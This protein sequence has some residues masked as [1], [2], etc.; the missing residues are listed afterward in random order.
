MSNLNLII[1][2]GGNSS[3]REVSI[4]TGEAIFN[5]LKKTSY[6]ELLDY[7]GNINEYLPQL[8]KAD[9]VVLAL[10]GGEGENG[11]I[12]SFFET[13]G[14]KFTGSNS[15]SSKIAMD[16]NQTKIIAQNNLIS[17]PKWL[18]Y[19]PKI[20][21]K[22]Q[23]PEIIKLGFPLV[24]KPS[25]EGSTMGL[26]IIQNDAEITI[27]LEL[28]LKY[29]NKVMFEE[30]IPG[31]ELTVG[32]LGDSFLPIVEIIPSHELYDYECKYTKGMSNYFCPAGIDV[33]VGLKIQEDALKI[34]GKIGCQHYS[35][36]DFRLN[37]KN[38]Y[39]MLEINTLPGMTSTS[40]LP[41]AANATGIS[42]DELLNKIIELAKK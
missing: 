27:A 17:T 25:D 13:N 22:E 28:A 41:K 8:I 11:E 24:V 37:D 31:R 7:K 6:V 14:I 3:E 21:F 4:S 42:F 19:N 12:Q 40:L 20:E 38:E 18:M 9:L 36:I 10:H 15:V 16:K 29:S 33:E 30:F 35:R 23:Y 34:H 32:V 2:C 1:L 5:S 39:F 26:S